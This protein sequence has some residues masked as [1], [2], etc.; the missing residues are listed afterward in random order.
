MHSHVPSVAQRCVGWGR[1]S[2]AI[3]LLL[4]GSYEAVQGDWLSTAVLLAPTVGSRPLNPTIVRSPTPRVVVEAPMLT[5][6]NNTC[7]IICTST[8]SCVLVLG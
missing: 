2:S 3:S 6:L 4:Q 7:I 8:C 5:S 1:W